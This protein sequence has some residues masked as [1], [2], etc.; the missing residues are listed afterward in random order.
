M[1]SSMRDLQ[2]SESANNE[3]LFS[4]KFQ[5]IHDDETGKIEVG[6]AMALMIGR[7]QMARKGTPR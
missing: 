7:S 6:S 5:R 3:I 4:V 1:A 2:P